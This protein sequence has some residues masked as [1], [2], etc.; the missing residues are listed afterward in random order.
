MSFQ[1]VNYYK[2]LNNLYSYTIIC[3][4]RTYTKTKKQNQEIEDQ[5][6][7]LDECVDC[8]SADVERNQREINWIKAALKNVEK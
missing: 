8:I 3:F 6:R 1:S 5:K 4:Y 7:F 2:C